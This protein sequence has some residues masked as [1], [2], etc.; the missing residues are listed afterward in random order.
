[1]KR[2]RSFYVLSGRFAH[3]RNEALPVQIEST[4]SGERVVKLT[5]GSSGVTISTDAPEGG[6]GRGSSFS[7]TDLLAAAVGS[8]ALTTVGLVIR[9]DKQIVGARVVIEKEMQP[10]PR[11]VRALKLTIH[12]PEG[13][14][15]D[16]RPE[17]EL[18]VKGCPVIRSFE[19]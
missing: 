12:L 8:C 13:V 4:Y 16:E 6:G 14:L 18:A 11:Q 17:L 10:N 7:P 1:M 9:E 19:S 15:A 2:R 3:L 5:H